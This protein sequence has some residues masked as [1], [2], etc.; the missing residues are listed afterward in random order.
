MARLNNKYTLSLPTR[1]HSLALPEDPSIPRGQLS[2]SFLA[3]CFLGTRTLKHLGDNHSLNFNRTLTVS[4]D[5]NSEMSAL[6][7]PGLVERR[8]HVPLRDWDH[9]LDQ[10]GGGTTVLPAL[11][12]AP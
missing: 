3:C 7:E 5:G 10:D 6:W 9:S 12:P 4:P 1:S 11:S 8:K 2:S